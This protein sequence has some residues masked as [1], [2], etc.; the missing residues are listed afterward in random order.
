MAT[1]LSRRMRRSWRLRLLAALLMPLAIIQ[2]SRA[3]TPPPAASGVSYRETP[4]TSLPGWDADSLINALPAVR[5]S[6]AVLA[7]RDDAAWIGSGL[8][9]V[10]AGRWKTVCSDLE[11]TAQSAGGLIDPP[12]F[13][14]F[15]ER[16]FTAFAVSA[17]ETGSS[18]LFTGYYQPILA[19]CRERTATCQTPIYGLPVD[20][21]GVDMASV[22][23]E[24]A[25][26]KVF[27]RLEGERLV[28][29]WTRAEIE[30]GAL[31]QSGPSAAPV[32]AWVENPVDAHILSIQGSGLIRLSDGS[33]VPLAY[34]GNNGWPY[35]SLGKI[36][37]DQGIMIPSQVTMPA[38][39]DWLMGH[40]G[41]AVG[42]MR[43]N[44]RA[45]F[46]RQSDRSE[47]KGSL[48]IAL[49]A[50]RTLAVDPSAIPLGV[51]VWLDTS[52]PDGRPV[53]RLMVAADTGAAIRGA[54][55]GD[56]FWGNDDLAFD[57]AGR[58][59]SPGQWFLLA[60]K[61]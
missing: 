39:R 37:V 13:R 10:P 51:P 55:R 46:F 1:D 28:S 31:S 30:G 15:L 19:G 53:R 59:K 61:S 48:G 23:P 52:D 24:L 44:P 3:P 18:G 6:C 42:L 8:A 58:M 22:T 49:V 2:C 40:P 25:G 12:T 41:Q 56:V 5:S 17:G 20:L 4:L 29:Y 38:I 26:T 47:A 34:A 9:A 60:P 50:G 45:I 11:R 21:V 16:R 35:K 36:L 27:G 7:E 57:L 43:Q 32:V 33:L 54:V 14:Q